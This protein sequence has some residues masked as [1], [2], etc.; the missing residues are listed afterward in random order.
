MCNYP[1]LK[2]IRFQRGQS[3]YS[4][5]TDT[6]GMNPWRIITNNCKTDKKIL[7]QSKGYSGAQGQV[8]M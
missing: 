4:M 8:W 5:F 3:L 7:L 1:W 2:A 6:A